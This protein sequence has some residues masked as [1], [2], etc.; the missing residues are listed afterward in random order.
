MWLSRVCREL[1]ISSQSRL[2][3]ISMLKQFGLAILTCIFAL[4]AGAITAVELLDL[5]SNGE[6]FSKFDKREDIYGMGE[7]CSTQSLPVA[8]FKGW[9]IYKITA[10]LWAFIPLS[11][12]RRM[13]HQTRKLPNVQKKCLTT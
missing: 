12:H 11:L 7:P 8:G 6:P 9:R 10:Q 4:V 2:L 5:L 1:R 3:I 13:A